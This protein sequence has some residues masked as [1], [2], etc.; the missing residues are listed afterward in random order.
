MC[1][2]QSFHWHVLAGMAISCSWVIKLTGK[3]DKGR[4]FSSFRQWRYLK[5][6]VKYKYF[7]SSAWAENYWE[8]C[9]IQR[10]GWE[11]HSQ[12]RGTLDNINFSF[13]QLP[14]FN[15]AILEKGFQFLHCRNL[16]KLVALSYSSS[17]LLWLSSFVLDL[18]WEL[19]QL[20]A[21]IRRLC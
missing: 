20:P 12:T 10:V 4:D 17:V 9:W 15:W 21:A 6:N 19:F 18:W 1:S 5:E 8:E 3:R 13:P 7:W 16:S 14:A 11:W 2:L